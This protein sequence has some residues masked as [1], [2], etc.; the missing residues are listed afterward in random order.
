MS[1]PLTVTLHHRDDGTPVVAVS[2]EIDMS[3]A[4][5]FRGALDRAA[6]EA[7]SDGDRLV[8]DLTEV[9]YLDSAGLTALFGHAERLDVLA[10]P[11]LDSVLTVSGLA[12]LARVRIG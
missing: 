7:S 1:T 6:E 8:V 5:T 4:A 10:P 9:E 12:D 11:L 3:N 2:G